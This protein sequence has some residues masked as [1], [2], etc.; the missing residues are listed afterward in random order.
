MQ[1]RDFI[2]GIGLLSLV[3]APVSRA[4]VIDPLPAQGVAL[5][6]RVLFGDSDIGQQ[7]VDIR[8]HSKAGHV[9]VEHRAKL[10]LRILFAVAYA[11]D[12]HSIEVWDGFTLKSVDSRTEENDV[13]TVVEGRATETGFKIRAGDREFSTMGRTVTSDSFWLAAAMDTP[14]VVNA[15]TGDAA[16]PTLKKLTD[17]RWSF[18]ADFKHGPIDATVRFDGGFLAEAVIDSDG[19]T[20]RLERM[21]S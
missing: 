10:E 18:K 3:G 21:K 19:H 20:V 8:E 15:R 6:Y 16:R 14:N 5:T 9:V 12:H 17:D 11:L 13:R 4:A 1:R 2:A 7:T